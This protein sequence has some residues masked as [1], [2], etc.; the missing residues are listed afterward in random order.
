M[1]SVF[2]PRHTVL[3]EGGSTPDVN[4][5]DG[6]LA[7]DVNEVDGGLAPDV[8]EVDGGLAPDVS[9]IDVAFVPDV[10]ELGGGPMTDPDVINGRIGN[11]VLVLVDGSVGAR[12][13]RFGS[14]DIS[15]TTTADPGAE[16]CPVPSRCCFRFL[17]LTRSSKAA[18]DS[19]QVLCL[20]KNTESRINGSAEVR[21]I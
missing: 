19:A 8:N 9:E 13:M 17:L 3:V 21:S 5:V 12:S 11:E 18:L 14:T 2:E 4:E 10:D 1:I 20:L 16:I 6:G 15:S 7:P